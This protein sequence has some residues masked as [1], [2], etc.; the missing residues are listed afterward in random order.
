VFELLGNY[1]NP[2]NPSTTI[3]FSVP[4]TGNANIVFYNSLGQLVKSIELNSISAGS[5]EYKF[6][7]ARFGKRVYFYQIKFN[8]SKGYNSNNR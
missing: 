1:P 7:A 3:K 4:E 8:G 5:N 6:N 2:F